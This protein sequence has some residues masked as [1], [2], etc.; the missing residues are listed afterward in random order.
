MSTIHKI[1]LT[2]GPCA[3]KSTAMSFIS[4]RLKSLG[5]NVLVVPEVATMMI[6]GG[7]QLVPKDESH[8]AQTQAL[9][10]KTQLQHETAFRKIAELSDKPTVILCDRGVMD[11]AA[12]TPPHI[13]QAIL[14]ENNW[15]NVGLRDKHYDA[16]IHLVSAAVGAKEFYTLENNAARTETP[17]VA[18]AIDQLILNSWVGHPHLRVIDNSTDFEDK[19]RRVTTAVCNVV[20]VPEPVERERKF[21]VDSLGDFGNV[22]YETVDIEQTYLESANEREV[23]RVRKRGQNGTYTYTHTVKK[24]IS[25]GKNVEVERTISGREYL[26]YLSCQKQNSVVVR[27]KRTCFLWENQYFELDRFESPI[28]GLLLL[29]AEIESDDEEVKL[30]PFIKIVREVTS[31]GDFSNAKIARA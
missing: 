15:T 11:G 29:E 3:G 25:P 7:V 9:L 1:V 22:R 18:A 31:E 5:F 13:W 17:E 21:L 27:K 6:L 2:G 12:F 8:I 20:G 14:D 23:H 24:H 28:D 10:T 26:S 4:D 16:V 19:I 30:P